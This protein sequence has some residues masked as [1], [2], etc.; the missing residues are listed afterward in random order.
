M[1][2]I[3]SNLKLVRSKLEKFTSNVDVSA[4]RARDELAE[5]LVQLAKEE[6]KGERG[7]VRM[8]RRNI[9]TAHP[10]G[11]GT[12]KSY[13]RATAG[14]PPMNRTG[15]LRRSI[16]AEFF[17]FGFANYKAIIGPTVIY[18]RAVELGGVY[19]P[20]SWRNTSAMAGFPYM[21]PAWD[22]FQLIQPAIIRKHFG[23]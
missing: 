14:E 9:S 17:T 22:K 4:R 10:R 18:G 8:Q 16:K 23:H 11:K 7:F 1:N 6:I 5:T 15:N 2:E 21:K 19:A 13:E 20:R 12:Y 3:T